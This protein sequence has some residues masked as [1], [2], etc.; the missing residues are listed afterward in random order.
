M[1]HKKLQ[2]ELQLKENDPLNVRFPNLSVTRIKVDGS[3][4]PPEQLLKLHP[5]L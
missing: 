2:P 1:W 3:V 4:P 5:E